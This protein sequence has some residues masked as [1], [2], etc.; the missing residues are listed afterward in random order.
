LV[1]NS[2]PRY[3]LVALITIIVMAVVSFWWES[4]R[5]EGRPYIT[6]DLKELSPD[7]VSNPALIEVINRLSEGVEQRFLLAIESD[8]EEQVEEAL[9]SLSRLLLGPSLPSLSSVNSRPLL[10]MIDTDK[11]LDALIPLLKDH[12]FNFLTPHQQQQLKFSTDAEM[13]SSAQ[14]QLFGF[15]AVARTMPITEDPFNFFSEYLA[16]LIQG[17]GQYG[18]VFKASD[19]RYFSVI[20]IN[21]STNALQID[22]QKRINALVDN[23]EKELVQQFQSLQFYRSGVFFFAA[24]AAL[25]SEKDIRF[26]SIVSSVAVVVFLLFTF[27]S[28]TPLLIP[29]IS[30]VSGLGVAFLVSFSTFGSV[31][32]ITILFGASL[33]GVVLDYSIHY[34]Y[35]F[36]PAYSPTEASVRSLDN[37]GLYRQCY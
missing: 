10:S 13:I 20:A 15:S 6:T 29:L 30:I 35:H 17:N 19:G 31:H 37:K 7:V 12:R 16:Q 9:S 1:V 34:F 22:Q 2:V 23:I 14:Q 8:Q 33:V 25:N 5:L 24:D 11:V 3:S 36:N 4:Q 18:E 28:L 21:I 32:I 26:I 27:S